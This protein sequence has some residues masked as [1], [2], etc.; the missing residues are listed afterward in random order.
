[1]F[2]W[3]EGSIVQSGTSK[4]AQAAPVVLLAG[5]VLVLWS[6]RLDVLALGDDTASVLGLDVRRTRVVTV[7]LAVLLAALAVTVA[8]PIGFVGLTAPVIARLV[9]G[10]V[11]GHG[12]AP[13]APAAGRA[14]RLRRR[15]RRRRAAAAGRPRGRRP[16]RSRPASSPRCSARR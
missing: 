8:G 11:P 13:A 5:I 14:G 6:R 4:V 9:A 16:S 1:M 15:A 12:A 7:L 2:A 3:G 10:R